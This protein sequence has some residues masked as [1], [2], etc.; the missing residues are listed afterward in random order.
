MKHELVPHQEILSEADTKKICTQLNIIK[1]QLPRMYDND[2]IVDVLG[3]KVGDVIKIVRSS[4]T[5][6]QTDYYRL[7]V[8]PPIK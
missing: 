4:Q 6:G 5:A 7:V 3:A 2:P 1:N 8:S